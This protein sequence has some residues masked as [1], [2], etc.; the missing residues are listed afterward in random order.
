M[1]RGPAPKDPSQRR[2]RNVDQVPGTQVQ[3][4]GRMRGPALPSP[5][6]VLKLGD[7]W[8]PMTQRWWAAWRRSAQARV[9]SPTAWESLLTTAILHHQ[10]WQHGRTELA[11]E[12][13]LREAKHGA[14]LEDQQRLRMNVLPPS[15]REQASTG[16]DEQAGSGGEQ[17]P[18]TVTRIDERR[19]RLTS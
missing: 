14:T 16:H 2:R 9:M 3:A 1:A 12:I 18:G 4:D 19:A 7:T 15:A 5:A 17:P 11:G 10:L 13:R 6:D 8:H